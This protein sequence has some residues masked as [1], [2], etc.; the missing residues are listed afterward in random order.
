MRKII[1]ISTNVDNENI[2]Y[3]YALCNDGTIWQQHE[4]E[5]YKIDTPFNKPDNNEGPFE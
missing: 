1:Q 4:G 2:E 3:L 5:W